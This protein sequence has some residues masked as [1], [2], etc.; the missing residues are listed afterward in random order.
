MLSR[1]SLMSTP[2][3]RLLTGHR[4]FTAVTALFSNLQPCMAGLQ[5]LS[6]DQDPPALRLRDPNPAR[7]HF[8]AKLSID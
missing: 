1:S 5:R 2:V 7:G 6:Q 3:N 8:L 4:T